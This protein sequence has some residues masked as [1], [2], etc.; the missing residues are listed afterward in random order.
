LSSMPL[1]RHFMI[2]VPFMAA[3]SCITRTGA[4]K[5]DSSGRRNTIKL[6]VAMTVHKRASDRCTREKDRSPGRPP[7]WQR[8]ERVLFRQAIVSG[9]S[10]EEAAL[11]VGVS[12]PLHR[13]RCPPGSGWSGL[14][15]PKH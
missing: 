1:S 3:A 6:E 13:C 4:F 9:R 12:A 14:W 10:S 8:E 2:D 11:D 5:A 15:Q 7:A